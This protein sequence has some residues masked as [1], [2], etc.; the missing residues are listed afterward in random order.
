MKYITKARL[1]SINIV[2]REILSTYG[3]MWGGRKVLHVR[4]HFG[5]NQSKP[6]MENA[7]QCASFQGTK[8]KKDDRNSFTRCREIDSFPHLTKTIDQK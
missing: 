6:K 5:E 7:L 4:L 3:H 2:S 8:K 1:R